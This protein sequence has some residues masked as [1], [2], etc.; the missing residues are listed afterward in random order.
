M[1]QAPLELSLTPPDAQ[2][3]ASPSG[4]RR[5]HGLLHDLQRLPRDFAWAKA[6]YALKH[7]LFA[8]TLR[9]PSF[10]PSGPEKIAPLSPDPWPGDAAHGSEIVQGRLSFAGRTIVD[11]HPLWHPP[12][13]S[14]AWL[15]NMHGFAWLRDLRAH[16]G[17]AAR[18]TARDLT[19]SWI[20]Q[21]KTWS[22]PAW[23]PDVIGRR[24]VSWLGQY[25][26]FA[27]SAEADF[28]ETLHR[29]LHRQAAHLAS[30]LPAGLAGRDAIAAIK[31]LIYAGCC[32]PEGAKW[33]AH[34]L[35]LLEQELHRQ[36]LTDGGQIERS[37]GQH[38][39]ILQDL[40]DIRALLAAASCE[41]PASLQA[42][43][44]GMTPI[45]RLMQHGDGGLALFNHSNEGAALQIELTLQR[46]INRQRPL[47][48]A[49]ETGFQR[50]Q[51][52]RSLLLVDAGPPPPSGYDDKA[53]AGTLSF[54]FSIGRERLIVNCGAQVERP[55]W[56]EVQRT[57]AAH[58]T[59][60]LAETNSSELAPERGF[61]KRIAAVTCRRSEQ[62]GALL[63]ETSH[64]G[65]QARFGAIH[66]RCLF[67]SASGDDLRGE[68]CIA[69]TDESQQQLP[70]AIRFHL[71]PSV[72]AS[73]VQGS[74]AV[75]LKTAKGMGW[76]LHCAGAEVTLD[77]SVYLGEPCQLRRGQQIVLRGE[78]LAKNT[79]VKWALQKEGGR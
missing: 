6:I 56:L 72:Q 61:G 22:A 38:L 39:A 42:A 67:L 65:Y 46:C 16:G 25:E 64:D 13:A 8:V 53:H 69:F 24:L 20:V 28:C 29:S 30:V 58:S 75:L 7:P 4:Q 34:G 66:H 21:N 9:L 27:A 3:R 52:G 18:R 43:I 44:T 71:H 10:L 35:Q 63:L 47:M 48:T 19:S 60:T 2:D 45:L 40:L 76:R 77:R 41:A 54:E 79:I 14:T 62:D 12:E 50:L 68:D 23:H 26:F 1:T 15:E 59:L 57:T 17:D 37:P 11:P 55:D 73:Q 36:I 78:T 31:G 33:Q 51:S 5:S 74:N 32:L 70:F 49:P